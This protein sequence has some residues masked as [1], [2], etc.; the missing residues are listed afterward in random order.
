MKAGLCLFRDY[1]D[2]LNENKGSWRALMDIP[3][4]QDLMWTFKQV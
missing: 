3:S 1:E 4:D 2:W